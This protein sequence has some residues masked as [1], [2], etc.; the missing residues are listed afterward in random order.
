MNSTAFFNYQN[1]TIDQKNDASLLSNQVIQWA[2]A[3]ALPLVGFLMLCFFLSLGG[4]F[5]FLGPS[6]IFIVARLIPGCWEKKT[7]MIEANES[8][9]NNF[10]KFTY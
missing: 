5:A 10:L 7:H 2:F 1:Y 3:L 4:T 9:R 8:Q 6:A